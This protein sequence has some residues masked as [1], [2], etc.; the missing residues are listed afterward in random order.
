MSQDQESHGTK[1][2]LG[3]LDSLSRIFRGREEKAEPE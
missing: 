1:E 3:F 2:G